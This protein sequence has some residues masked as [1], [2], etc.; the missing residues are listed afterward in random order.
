MQPKKKLFP[1][2][3]NAKLTLTFA[4]LSS[5]ILLINPSYAARQLVTA[6]ANINI[7]G[8]TDGI[9]FRTNNTLTVNGAVNIGKPAN[10]EISVINATTHDERGIL[11]FTDNNSTVLGSIT[12]TGDKLGIIDL[13]GTNTSTIT[14]NGDVVV[15]QINFTNG[16]SNSKLVIADTVNI[17]T[18]KIT[19]AVNDTGSL[20]LK[21]TSIING[22]IGAAGKLISVIDIAGAA[23]KT[24]T[25]TG[26]INV[27][28]IVV[29]S[30]GTG[31][32]QKGFTIGNT[33]Q[34][35][36]NTGTVKILADSSTFN[37]NIKGNLNVVNNKLTVAN[38]F[39]LD[40]NSKLSIDLAGPATGQFGQV[41][42]QGM[43]KLDATSTLAVSNSVP[44]ADGSTFGVIQSNTALPANL[45]LIN[46]NNQTYSFNVTKTILTPPGAPAEQILLTVSRKNLANN[47][48]VNI[49]P[50]IKG[51]LS[52][53]DTE[54]NYG[55]IANA[56][57][58][59]I[60]AINSFEKT[61]N[62]NQ[63]AK[64][65]E[66]LT[67]FVDNGLWTGSINAVFNG[68]NTVSN[69]LFNLKL[70]K[71]LNYANKINNNGFNS[72]DGWKKEPPGTWV[73]FL[74]KELNQKDSYGISGFDG[75]QLGFVIG[76]D[77]SCTDK[78]KLGLAL[79]YNYTDLDS[80]RLGGSGT[81]INTYHAIAYSSMYFDKLSVYIDAA[82]SIAQH[83]YNTT[84]NIVI[85]PA[86]A[87]AA[88]YNANADFSAWQYNI[89]AEVGYQW[90]EEGL[91]FSPHVFGQ[92]SKLDIDEYS[93]TGSNAFALQNV[94]YNDLQAN[95]LGAGFRTGYVIVGHKITAFPYLKL[96][97]AYD[98][99]S[100]I[101]QAISSFPEISTSF[102]TKG[103]LISKKTFLADLGVDWQY[104]NHY[105]SIKYEIE[106]REDFF[107][108]GGFIRYRYNW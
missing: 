51:L 6:D 46:G 93:E 81:N 16:V 18:N 28:N 54:V 35:V 60:N 76:H 11:K 68:I 108:H 85:L 47:P 90:F 40:T 52:A 100:D 64:S 88:S 97:L 42:T 23:N 32:F 14:L 66:T 105:Y 45:P 55:N 25:F 43:S 99:K 36:N 48:A 98:F 107:M 24:A 67:P 15:G 61:Q 87:N 92:Y 20:E 56:S 106:N 96:A 49:N 103:P 31:V 72:G 50:S 22:D 8:Q 13:S 77:V 19:T 34:I 94:K 38:D 70:P 41:S 57:D 4:L 86:S 10:S 101:S 95:I 84:R 63:L 65:A 30:S 27:N 44:I 69:H 82:L 53:I 5:S 62:S 21:G 71:E 29:S 58:D 104:N 12:P 89:W 79:N 73:Q 9:E 26:D 91:L 80:N 3:P 75:Y 17:T 102:I 7:D 59:F 39:I 37:A 2:L 83:D 74:G 1:K 78:Y 33:L